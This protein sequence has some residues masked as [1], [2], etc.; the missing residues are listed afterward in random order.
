[1]L[2]KLNQLLAFMRGYYNAKAGTRSSRKGLLKRQQKGFKSLQQSLKNSPFYSDYQGR[3]LSDYPVINKA[4]HMANFDAI[5]VAGLEKEKALAIAINSEQSRDFSPCYN[6]YSVGLSSGTSGNRGLF[7]TAD[8]E[9]AEWA[10]Y[11]ISK[12]LPFKLKKQRVAFFLRANNNLY[13]GSNG[14]LLK[15]RFFDLIVGIESQ[16]AVLEKFQPTVLIAPASVLVKIMQAS[17]DIHPDKIISVAE[18]L[19]PADEAHL[20]SYFN[21]PIA[22]I[23]QCTEGFLAATCSHG[24]L[25]M[26]EDIVIIEKKWVDQSSGR[27]SPIVTDLRRVTQPV[28][29]YLLDDI[30]IED[31][32]PCPCGSSQMRL[33]AIEGRMDDILELEGHDKSLVDV[34]PDFVRNSIVS[35]C[36]EL[37]EYRVIQTALN[38]LEISIQPFDEIYQNKIDQGLKL[39]WDRLGVKIPRY[40]FTALTV[41][42]NTQKRRR[43]SREFHG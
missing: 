18:V 28:V 31:N 7:V 8:L 1:M 42:D 16:M 12:M 2:S 25:H 29:R 14:L 10:G 34:F 6:G 30:L 3:S 37:D 32:S 26:N 24:N 43:V 17:P 13:E 22:Q 9:R 23:Y 19:E 40:H 35:Y 4:I 5:N 36:P 33:K 27:F 21:Q 15:F 38:C 20:S 39:L 41:Q 11:I